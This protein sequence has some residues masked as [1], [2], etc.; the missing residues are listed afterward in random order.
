MLPASLTDEDE[1]GSESKSNQFNLKKY[2]FLNE[3]A[4]NLNFQVIQGKINSLHVNKDL[5]K[6]I[7]EVLCRKNKNNPMIVG[8]AGVGKTAL[9][10]SL[11][12]AIVDEMFRFLS[13]ET[14]LQFRYPYGYCW[15]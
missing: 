3:Y 8:E 12:Q 1:E 15:L 10:E 9:V 4:T 2:N 6:K 14:H 13:H 11:A 5:V 7:S